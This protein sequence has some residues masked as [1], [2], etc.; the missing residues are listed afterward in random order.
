MDDL[1]EK[2]DII[3][4][5]SGSLVIIYDLRLLDD[6]QTELD[7]KDIQIT[8]FHVNY[9]KKQQLEYKSFRAYVSILYSK[10][11]IKIYIQNEKV[12]TKCLEQKLYEPRIYAYKSKQFKT[13]ANAQKEKVK[14]TLKI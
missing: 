10:P 6:G 7:Q 12:K 1:I 2:L 3:D 9:Y 11:N 5:K 14:N 8:N 4:G 13:L